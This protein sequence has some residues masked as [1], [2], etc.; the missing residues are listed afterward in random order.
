ME[1]LTSQG[2]EFDTPFR[3]LGFFGVPFRSSVLLQPTSGTLVNLT[4][5][6]AFVIT[7]DELELVH[8]ER[9]SF[10]L[11][12][13]D[14]VFIFKDYARKVEMVQQVPMAKLDNV[15]EWLDSCEIRYTEGI[16]S[17]NWPKVMKTIVSDPDEFFENGGWNFL[18]TAASDDE[19]AGEDS[20]EED[21][22]YRM[23]GDEEEE[24]AGSGSGSGDDDDSEAD[25]DED[26][27]EA[28]S[29]SGSEA[30]TGSEEE[31]G[32]DWSDLEEEARRGSFLLPSS[33]L[34]SFDGLPRC[35]GQG[36]GDGGGRAARVE[37]QAQAQVLQ[38][39]RLPAPQEAQKVQA[40]D[41]CP[42]LGDARVFVCRFTRMKR[43]PRCL[44]THVDSLMIIVD[45]LQFPTLLPS[46]SCYSFVVS[47]SF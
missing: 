1:K 39:P 10:Q 25:S 40:L 43:F 23:S 11:K 20:D 26:S 5:W 37:L 21:E 3:E 12:N 28:T 36:G 18:D 35:S 31:S 38:G 32:K 17:L 44:E 7:L 6:P 14:M 30:S 13:F 4:E 2:V 27:P 16:Q 29:D 22:E 33:A 42:F 34:P 45:C 8:F 24:G 41:L 19:E 9:V 47:C 15:K 46:G